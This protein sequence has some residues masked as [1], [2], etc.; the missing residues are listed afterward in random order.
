MDLD[1]TVR[2]HMTFG[3]CSVGHKIVIAIQNCQDENARLSR[4]LPDLS[5]RIEANIQRVMDEYGLTMGEWHYWCKQ[6]RA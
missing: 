2:E 3:Q 6:A 1:M 5:R 4:G